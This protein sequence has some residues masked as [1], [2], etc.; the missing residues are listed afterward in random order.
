MWFLCGGF[1]IVKEKMRG[2][3]AESRRPD[4]HRLHKKE[5]GA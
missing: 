4:R 5:L 2:F 3:G 1:G